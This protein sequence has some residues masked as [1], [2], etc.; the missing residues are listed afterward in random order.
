MAV[1]IPIPSCEG[2]D[3]T[4]FL[5]K[6]FSYNI[7]SVMRS[8]VGS[9]AQSHL[10]PVRLLGSLNPTDKTSQLKTDLSFETGN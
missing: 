10:Y 4:E 5:K 3:F 8:P 9:A 1:A 2:Q 6:I 7:G